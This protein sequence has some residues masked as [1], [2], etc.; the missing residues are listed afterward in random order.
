MN[1]TAEKRLDMLGYMLEE[2]SLVETRVRSELDAAAQEKRHATDQLFALRAGLRKGADLLTR[3]LRLLAERE[4]RQRGLVDAAT[5]RVQSAK[6]EVVAASR[7]VGDGARAASCCPSGAGGLLC[8]PRF[9]E[10][11]TLMSGCVFT[12]AATSPSRGRRA[13]SWSRSICCATAAHMVRFPPP[14]CHSL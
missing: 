1:W 8:L 4:Q 9:D 3:E 11:R 13:F 7:A 10:A 14:A 12:P 6:S 2:L 5:V